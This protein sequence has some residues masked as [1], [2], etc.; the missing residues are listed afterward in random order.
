[1]GII[2]LIHGVK[3]MRFTIVAVLGVTIWLCFS[4]L[5]FSRQIPPRHNI[6]LASFD[7]IQLGSTESQVTEILGVP[8]GQHFRGTAIVPIPPGGLRKSPTT[9]LGHRLDDSELCYTRI[10]YGNLLYQEKAWIGDTD[11]I[12]L[13]FDSNGALVRKKHAVVS[14]QRETI[15]ETICR[16][17]D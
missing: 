17:F 11:S 4:W 9:F 6:N 5:L 3:S 12:W 7:K 2:R 14:M 16:W 10:G 15:S 1:M 8:Y 13:T